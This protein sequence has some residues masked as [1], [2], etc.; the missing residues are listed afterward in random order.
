MPAATETWG[1]YMLIRA[2][3]HFKSADRPCPV[4]C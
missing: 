1:V 2:A 4:P 3:W